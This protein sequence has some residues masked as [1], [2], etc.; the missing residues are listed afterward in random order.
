MRRV[1]ALLTLVLLAGL[2]PAQQPAYR[3][4]A[5]DA[6]RV[7]ATIG[8]EIRM[9]SFA[10]DKWMVF[11]PEPPELP[12]QRDV[13]VKAAPAGKLVFEKSALGRRV[14]FIEMPVTKPTPGR[15][16][17]MQIEV[18]VTLRTRRLVP[19]KAGEKPPEVSPLTPREKKYYLSPTTSV[20]FDAP[21]FRNWLDA[22]KL[23]CAKGEHPVDFA[24]RVL[25]VIRADYAYAYDPEEDKRA[26]QA[27]KAK[28]TDCGGMS[29]LLV[30]AM[31]ANEIP[32]RLL[33]GREALP[34]KPGSDPSQTEYDRPH[35]RAEFFVSGTGWVPIDP[36]H[37]QRNKRRPVAAF[38][39]NDAADLLVL[40]VDV[41]LKLPF[42]DKV[43][44]AQFLQLGPY[45]W[46]TGTGTFDG[47]FG[48]TAW[49]LKATPI[50][51][52]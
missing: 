7:A 52:R 17:T 13:K 26:S 24:A 39:G 3:I 28:A 27:C 29:A 38:V 15:G 51:Q 18:E 25:E 36:A 48:P 32:A 14:R 6:K 2:A 11:L 1:L 41:D 45:Y 8:Y 30:G 23:R 4:E 21:A 35:I 22:K 10:V 47:S 19:L 5:A 20:D 46:A 40:H 31:R 50:R 44:E 49:E 16:L 9:K 12:S 42:P 43:R 34:R 33:V 37:A